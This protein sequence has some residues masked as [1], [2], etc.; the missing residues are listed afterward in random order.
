MSDYPFN[1][2]FLMDPVDDDNV[3]SF[4]MKQSKGPKRSNSFKIRRSG[5]GNYEVVGNPTGLTRKS[6][7][8][9]SASRNS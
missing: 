2:N 3:D 7:N 8:R 6:I 1:L 4:F 5:D 9:G